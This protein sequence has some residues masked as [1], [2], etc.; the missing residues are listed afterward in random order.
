MRKVLTVFATGAALVGLLLSIHWMKTTCALS[1]VADTKPISCAEFWLN[2]YQTFVAGIIAL[3]GAA[4]TIAAIRYQTLSADRV[5]RRIES[6]AETALREIIRA[7]TAIFAEVW[8]GIDWAF[9]PGIDDGVKKKRAA[10]I[11]PVY[12]HSGED[13]IELGQMQALNKLLAPSAQNKIARLLLTWDEMLL[14]L[15]RVPDERSHDPDFVGWLELLRIKFSFITNAL[16][17]YDP[18]MADI[19]AGLRQPHVNPGNTAKRTAAVRE[20]L[21]NGVD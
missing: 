1:V 3:L 13:R 14:H 11:W 15:D 8:R 7:R 10:A 17:R 20:S 18:L 2:R 16:E 6:E 5:A 9:E 21:K 19:F 12:W 4:A